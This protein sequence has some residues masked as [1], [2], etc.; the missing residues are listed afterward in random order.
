MDQDIS[1][2][3]PL[4]LVVDDD[5]DVLAVGAAAIEQLGYTVLVASNGV[6][7]LEVIR[8]NAELSILFSDISMPGMDG[9]EL[10]HA[11]L[12]MR[13]GLRIIL[14]SGARPPTTASAFVA[15]PYRA[16][17]LVNALSQI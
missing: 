10:A 17:D 7:A 4:V 2:R 12:A 8:N 14:T 16:A 1:S 6:D 3:G 5:E 13:P 9:E 15:K 11:A